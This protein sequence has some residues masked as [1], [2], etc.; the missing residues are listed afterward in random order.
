MKK[1]GIERNHSIKIWVFD[2]IYIVH[3]IEELSIFVFCSN[4]CKTIPIIF[5]DYTI[6]KKNRHF[7]MGLDHLL[8]MLHN[9]SGDRRWLHR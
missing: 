1:N 5:Q 9:A 7:N 2:W 8:M 6:T 3:K 4:N